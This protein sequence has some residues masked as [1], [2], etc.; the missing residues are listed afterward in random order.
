[1]PYLT[2]TR[3]QR[4][5]ERVRFAEA[6]P[7][8]LRFPD[9][10]RA[11][12]KLKVVSLTGGL[13]VLPYPV[14]QGAVAKVMF[15]TSAG[16]VLGSAEMLSPMSWELQPFKFVGLPDDDQTRLETAIQSCLAQTQR[17]QSR[18]RR[19]HNQLENFRAW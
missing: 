8:V 3:G 16:S 2:Q 4:R 18:T 7:V 12:G 1:M 5:A 10:N 11:S 17:E 15:L 14:R 9:G 6:T 19:D 13:L